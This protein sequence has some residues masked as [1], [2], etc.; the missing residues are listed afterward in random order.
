M[1]DTPPALSLAGITKSFD[2]LVVDHLD[3]NVRQGELYALL[4]S[5]GAGKTTTLR[6]VS[7]LL[8]PD[9]GSVHI[10][11]IDALKDPVAAKKLTAW[12]PAEPMI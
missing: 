6:M 10:F 8:K 5:N 1:S 7:G 3:L 9:A 4:G 2:R 12:L 11:G